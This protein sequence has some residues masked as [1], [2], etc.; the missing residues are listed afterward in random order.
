MVNDEFYK[1]KISALIH[2]PPHKPW[3]LIKKVDHEEKAKELAERIFDKEMIAYLNDNRV[4]L[5]DKLASSFD[6]WI[7]ST[8]VGEKYIPGVFRTEVLKVKNILAPIFSI[9]LSSNYDCSKFKEYVKELSIIIKNVQ[10]WKFKYHLMYLLYES[11][12]ISKGLSVGPADTRVPTHTVF[13]H[14]YAT[15]TMI[16]WVYKGRGKIEGL[17]VGLDVAGVQNFISSSR[18]LRDMWVSSYIVSALTWYAVVELVEKLGPDIVVIPSLRMNPFYLHWLKAKLNVDIPE[19]IEKLTYIT[20][21]DIHEMYKDLGIPPYAIMPGR[22]TLVLP[23]WPQVREIVE[24]KENCKEYFE[25]RFKEGWRLLWKVSRKV[26]E[27]KRHKSLTWKFI[28]EVFRYYER[29]IFKT[30]EFD[31]VPPLRLRVEYVKIKESAHKNDLWRLYDEKYC[32]LVRKLGLTKYHHKEPA[33]ELS[34]Y[35]LTK[36]VFDNNLSLGFPKPSKRG[37]DYCTLCGKLPAILTLPAGESEEPKD[38]EFGFTIFCTVEK[39]LTPEEIDKVWR[40]KDEREQERFKKLLEEFTSL[41]GGKL[42]NEL[43]AF[44][45]VFSP[46]EKLCPWCFLKR[47]ISLEPRILDI[48]LRGLKEDEI[49]KFID[50]EKITEERKPEVKFPS[51]PHLASTRL[52]NKLLDKIEQ[53]APNVKLETHL[54]LKL[55]T[56]PKTIWAWLFSKKMRRQ[57]EE[58]AKSLKEEDQ[59]I[60]YTVYSVDPEETWF[61]IKRRNNWNNLL[62]VLGLIKWL[63]RYYAL[64]KADGDSIGDLLEGKVTSFLAGK[65]DKNFYAKAKLSKIRYEDSNKVRMFLQQYIK[66]SCEDAFRKFI[67]LC[68]DCVLKEPEKG[69]KVNLEE[70][71]AKMIARESKISEDEAR[72]RVKRVLEFFKELLGKEMRIIV[73]PSYHV[74]ISSALMRTALLDIAIIAELD[75]FTVYAGGDDLLTF[76][77]VDKVSDIVYN[78]RRAYGGLTIELKLG[79]NIELD[80]KHPGFLR[81]YNAYLPMLPNVG[82]SYCVYIAHYRYPLSLILGRVIDLIDEAKD[83]CMFYYYDTEVGLMKSAKD[84]FVIA[85]NPRAGTEDLA[86]LPISWRRPIVS[87]NSS[88]SDIAILLSIVKKLL[89]YIDER[90]IEELTHKEAEKIIKIS[91]SLLYDFKEPR[92]ENILSELI[93][94]LI[95][96]TYRNETINIIKDLTLNIIKRNITHKHEEKAKEI[97]KQVFNPLLSEPKKL[98]GL[99]FFIKTESLSEEYLHREIYEEKGKKMY[100]VILGIIDT[101]RMIRSGMR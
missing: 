3:L 82:R 19:E 87:N 29:S 48:L 65:I 69:L 45:E 71:C 13:D 68:I 67:S 92:V 36:E 28:Y 12:W 35:R 44:K 53:V 99:G 73:S 95:R 90:L 8:L 47:V 23:S 38:D 33:T 94:A 30:S 61:H 10:D 21:K 1:L 34:I 11:L 18:K 37:F 52:Y 58:K 101:V 59:Y 97:F 6:R 14:D 85:Y 100:N 76:T 26:A 66:S 42:R 24:V 74:A 78:T 57:V 41:Y 32:E 43:I 72:T 46:G 83:Y 7:L 49:E 80:K 55:V 96:G 77:P 64:V 27:R 50:D 91:H 75:G 25:K 56:K 51:L 17:I 9:T 70:Q 86:L 40:F 2:D 31:R 20:V 93:L 63:W 62:R 60:L 81:L 4:N 5:A 22:V 88:H 54:P 16:N 84:I 89:T 39:G 98:I 79:E 15:V